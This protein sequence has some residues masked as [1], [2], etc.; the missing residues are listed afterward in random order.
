MINVPRYPSTMKQKDYK[1]RTS[2]EPFSL[3]SLVF[4]CSLPHQQFHKSL[5]RGASKTERKSPRRVETF[6][7]N[8]QMKGGSKHK[9]GIKDF[10]PRQTLV[11]TLSAL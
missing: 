8:S 1:L 10:N 5:S 7:E 3:Y 11:K 4:C 6:A 2:D 9:K